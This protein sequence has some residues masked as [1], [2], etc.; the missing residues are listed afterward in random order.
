MDLEKP[1][2]EPNLDFK[3]LSQ[4][5][6]F[7]PF[8]EGLPYAP[9]KAQSGPAAPSGASQAGPV[10]FAAPAKIVPPPVAGPGP[11]LTVTTPALNSAGLNSPTPAAPAA[12][13]MRPL[14]PDGPTG[15]MPFKRMMAW[16][17]D[18]AL[19]TGVCAA[20]LFILLKRMSIPTDSLLDPQTV[21]MFGGFLLVFNWA[22]IVAEEIAFG[23]TPGK[24]MFGLAVEGTPAQLF[25]RSVTFFVG[26]A[27]LGLGLLPIF[28][29]RDRRG[30]HDLIAG[31]HPREL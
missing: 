17:F 20:A 14:I 23:T 7:H 13:I 25:V 10:R 8:S 26:L 31:T 16:L 15:L 5:L 2:R 18:V 21:L 12:E 29:R 3:P 9:N 4:G 11:I 6:G 24:R 1:R 27:A 19:H 30:L 22:L 28:L